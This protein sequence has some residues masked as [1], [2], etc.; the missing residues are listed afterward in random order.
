MLRPYKHSFMASNSLRQ[1]Y[2][3]K[4]DSI[5]RLAV[6]SSWEDRTPSQQIDNL[7]YKSFVAYRNSLDTAEQ[8]L[9]L[10]ADFSSEVAI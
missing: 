6:L 3:L 8:R 2:T 9:A 7:I 5:A 10:D 1:S 4:L